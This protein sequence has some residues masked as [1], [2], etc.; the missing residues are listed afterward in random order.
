M[1]IE[2]YFRPLRNPVVIGTVL[3]IGI[4]AGAGFT[5]LNVEV[6][7]K[8]INRMYSEFGGQEIFLSIDEKVNYI[9]SQP[10]YATNKNYVEFLDKV[11]PIR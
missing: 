3:G 10:S 7:N 11:K 4:L 9:R 6:N 5:L 8:K 2:N 1:A